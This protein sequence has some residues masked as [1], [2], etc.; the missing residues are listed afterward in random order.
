MIVDRSFDIVAPVMH[1]YSYQPFLY[2]TAQIQN[3]NEVEVEEQYSMT[4]H[5]LDENDQ[6]WTRFRTWHFAEVLTELTSEVTKFAQQNSDM[7]RMPTWELK[8][9]E[10]L[11]VISRIPKY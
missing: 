1:D 7:G 9:E 11:D 8:V 2:D 3:M 10:T 4:Y 5:K 6:L